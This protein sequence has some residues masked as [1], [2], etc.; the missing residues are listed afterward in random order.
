MSN[1]SV[2]SNRTV[3]DGGGREV[4]KADY[5]GQVRDGW[6]DRGKIENDRY[7]DEYGRD[8]GWVKRSSGSSSSSGGGGLALIGLL[9]IFGIYYLMFLGIKW[10]IVQGKK[11]KAHASRSWGI[12]SMFFPPFFIL[13][14]KKGYSAL[15][16]LQLS[17]DPENQTKVAKAG[18]VFGYF[19]LALSIMAVIGLIITIAENI[20]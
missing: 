8:R 19:G 15:S 1:F 20:Y 11:S 6:H 2:D 5:S 16:D 4:G 3:R 18:I 12:A 7:T 17:G 9:L 14:L 10:L 13:A